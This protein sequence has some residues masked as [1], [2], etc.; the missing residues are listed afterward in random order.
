[1][2]RSFRLLRQAERELDL[3]RKWY[4]EQR[5]GLGLIFF[6]AFEAAVQYV[7]EFPDAEAAFPDPAFAKTV[8][9]VPIQGFPFHIVTT[10]VDNGL[11]VIAVAHVKRKPGYWLE[12][13]K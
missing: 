6:D 8:R 2:I 1:L 12:R 10:L 5:Y 3:A 9:R 11:I 7:Q 13:V 4:D